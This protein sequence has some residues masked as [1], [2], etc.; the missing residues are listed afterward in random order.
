M[1]MLADAIVAVER[2]LAKSPCRHPADRWIVLADRAVTAEFGWLLHYTNKLFLDSGNFRHAYAGT[3]PYIVDRNGRIFDSM[4]TA[5]AMNVLAFSVDLTPNK[6]RYRLLASCKSTQATQLVRCR[7]CGHFAAV[8]LYFPDGDAERRGAGICG[9]CRHAIW[10]RRGGPE[11]GVIV[12]SGNELC[13][14][15]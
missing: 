8:Q 10:V 7:N 5:D 15:L 1:M 9:N 3:C 12:I 14:D 6:S 13:S 2:I 11:S 4:P